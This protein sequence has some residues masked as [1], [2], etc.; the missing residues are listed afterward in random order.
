[1]V[2]LEDLNNSYRSKSGII[3]KRLSEFRQ[4]ISDRD[5]KKIFEEM[6]FCILTAGTSAQ[7]C[8]DV[9]KKVRDIIHTG[10]KE[11]ITV[12]LKSCYRFYNI[13]AEYI[14][15]TRE[16]LKAECD[17][18]LGELVLSLEDPVYRR[19]FFAL[20]KRIKG[21]GFKESSHFLRNIGFKGYAILDK[22]I[23]NSL[24]EL[25]VLNENKTPAG[26]SKYLEIEDKFINFA[27]T[28]GFDPDELDL[29]IWSEK[30]GTILK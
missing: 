28:N 19:D 30:T 18:R 25:K 21:L 9:I 2:T 1:M 6:V 27:R 16:Y 22:H 8:L 12:G 23:I 7:L 17:L 11:E 14:F 29:L 15:S 26:R 24:Y 13:R 5:D 20:N 10:N 3:K 4:L